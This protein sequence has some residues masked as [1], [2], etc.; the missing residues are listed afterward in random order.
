MKAL[1][2]DTVRAGAVAMGGGSPFGR[3][4]LFWPRPKLLPPTPLK[5]MPETAT[6]R[7]ERHRE[8]WDQK[9]E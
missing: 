4:E 1:I 3:D 2:L 7:K 9:R 8:I 6:K 5:E